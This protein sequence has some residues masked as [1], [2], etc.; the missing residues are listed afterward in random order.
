MYAIRRHCAAKNA[1]CW[2]V[3]FSRRGTM[4][5]KTFYDLAC[6]GAKKAKAQAI[7]WR[8]AQLTKLK[9]LTLLDLHKRKRSNNQSGMSGVHFHKTARQPL[10]FWQAKIRFHDGTRKARSF[11]VQKFG[12]KD[13]FCLAVAA[14][15]EMLAMVENRP[16]LHSQVAKRLNRAASP[17]SRG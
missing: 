16:F 8:D 1:W 4:Y 15:A 7:A 11:S 2:R 9:A 12:D 3:R 13:A 10:G 6:G 17:T 14:R 5:S